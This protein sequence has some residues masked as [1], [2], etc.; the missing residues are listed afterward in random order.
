MFSG[1]EAN[2]TLRGRQNNPNHCRTSRCE[3][4]SDMCL[5]LAMACCPKGKSQ[6]NLIHEVGGQDSRRCSPCPL[7]QDM[8]CRRCGKLDTFLSQH[9][10]LAGTADSAEA[11][12]GL[13]EEGASHLCTP[14]IPLHLLGSYHILMDRRHTLALLDHLCSQKDSK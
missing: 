5:L 11:D 2:G 3:G 13:K 1:Q 9:T 8:C 7:D 10:S 14:Y 6:H 4:S 12:R